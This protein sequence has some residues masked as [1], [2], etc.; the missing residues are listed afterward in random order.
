MPVKV[1]EFVAGRE[2][3]FG[4]EPRALETFAITWTDDKVWTGKRL[5]TPRS[6]GCRFQVFDADN[7]LLFDTKDCFDRANAVNMLDH[8]LGERTEPETPW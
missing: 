8:W 5:S 6:G 7:R 2:M 1:V 3:T 4:V